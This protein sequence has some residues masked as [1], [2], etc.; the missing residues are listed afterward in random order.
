[1]TRD[2]A[3]YEEGVT[4]DSPSRPEAAMRQAPKV[5]RAHAIALPQSAAAPG[6]LTEWIVAGVAV[7][8]L[9]AGLVS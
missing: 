3:R 9:L 6:P 1:V 4:I 7:L 8:L 2:A 5:S